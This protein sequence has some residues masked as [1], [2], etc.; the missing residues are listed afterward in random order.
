MSNFYY[1]SI[2]YI[3]EEARQYFE[4]D[5]PQ[6]QKGSE[7]YKKYFD[8][9]RHTYG[10]A[11][12]TR[13]FGS[14]VANKLGQLNEIRVGDLSSKEEF[15][16]NQDL[17]NNSVGRSIGIKTLP[18]ID[19]AELV[20]NAIKSGKLIIETDDTRKYDSTKDNSI[21]NVL[22]TILPQA[23]I[24]STIDSIHN[25]F[26][27][28]LN[29]F[30]PKDPLVIDLNGDG[31]RLGNWQESGVSFD[32]DGNG[33]SENAGWVMGDVVE[34][35][36]T[37]NANGYATTTT[38]TI[39]K[40]DVA[41]PSTDLE[42]ILADSDVVTTTTTTEFKNDDVFLV[43]DKNGNNVI[44]DI[45]ELFGNT[46]VSGFSELSKYDSNADRIIDDKDSQFNLLKLWNDL[47]Y[48][49]FR[50]C[51]LAVACSL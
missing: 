16:K 14:E 48:G 45:S 41:P 39:K 36:V 4:R 24:N 10:S 7:E 32:L 6:Y 38:T 5:F 8:A 3:R 35:R 28:T 22:I 13:E 20:S 49:V 11:V 50:S 37:T 29:S 51:N 1:L 12:L 25:Q 40:E 47:R 46:Q 23:K 2:N 19:I 21:F 42:F 33:F 18:N 27:S 44:D 9:Y 34:Y 31:L 30:M 17:F 26:I 43:L 15:Q